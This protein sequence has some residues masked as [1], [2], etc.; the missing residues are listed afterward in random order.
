MRERKNGYGYEGDKGEM[1]TRSEKC[2]DWIG[3]IKQIM[4]KNKN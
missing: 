1:A 3:D 4:W 2:L